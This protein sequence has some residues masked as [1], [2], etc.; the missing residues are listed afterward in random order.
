[1]ITG[2]EG[3][4]ITVTDMVGRTVAHVATATSSESIEI[5]GVTGVYVVRLRYAGRAESI[6]VQK[7]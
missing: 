1:T 7:R 5:D 4:E 6:L 3:V 2:A